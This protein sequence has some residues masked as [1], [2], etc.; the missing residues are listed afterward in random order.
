[1][2]LIPAIDLIEGK[3]V[4]LT[5]GDYSTR[6]VY[7]ADPL[8]VAL[9]FESVGIERLHVVDLDGAKAG[10]IVNYNVL[11]RLASRTR[12]IIDFGGGLKSDEDL[13][14][15]FDCG[16]QMITGGSIA[17]KNPERFLTWLEKYGGERVILGA[18][19]KD[20]KIAVSGWEEGTNLDLIPFVKDYREKGVQ[21]IICTDIGRDGMLQGPAIDLYKEIK[22]EVEG[23]YV[24]ASGGVSSMADIERLDEAGIPAVIFGKAIY[25]GRI[26]MSE[27]EK[28]VLKIC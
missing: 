24:I 16:A 1:M 12:L 4:R 22:E 27:I 18:D 3:C 7:N 9:Q 5:Q 14:I 10:H 20:K 28:Y 21:K 17:V 23:L 25:E 2:E 6:K 26:R 15:A 13:R 8:E 19:A 11:E